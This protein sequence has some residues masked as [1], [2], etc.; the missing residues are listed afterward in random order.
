MCHID[1]IEDDVVVD[2]D[3]KKF[4]CFYVFYALIWISCIMLI[5]NYDQ[6]NMDNLPYGHCL[7]S[8]VHTICKESNGNL[9]IN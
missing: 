8:F 4:Y 1:F 6:S 2:A 7:Q 9:L 3:M 5:T